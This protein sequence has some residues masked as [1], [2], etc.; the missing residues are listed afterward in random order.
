MQFLQCT[1]V[2]SMIYFKKHFLFKKAQKDMFH[3]GS[4]FKDLFPSCACLHVYH[5]YLPLDNDFGDI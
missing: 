1:V 5:V 3:V 4:G 2:V